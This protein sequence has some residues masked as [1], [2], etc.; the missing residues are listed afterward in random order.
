MR[1]LVDAQ[2]PR[3]ICI[4]LARPDHDAVHVKDVLSAGASDAD[5]WRFAFSERRIVVTKDEDFPRRIQSG[6]DGP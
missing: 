2:L 5:I 6:A 4:L 1:F 3:A